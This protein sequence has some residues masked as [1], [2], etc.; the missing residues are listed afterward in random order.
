MSYLNWPKKPFDN[1]PEIPV[2]HLG[3]YTSTFCEDFSMDHL[4]FGAVYKM[5]GNCLPLDR[6]KDSRSYLCDYEIN[7]AFPDFFPT[8]H[9]PNEELGIPTDWKFDWFKELSIYHSW[10]TFGSFF[11]VPNRIKIFHNE[12][13][14]S[15]IGLA[16]SNYLVHGKLLTLADFRLCQRLNTEK[17]DQLERLTVFLSFQPI[18]ITKE[19]LYYFL[20][21]PSPESVKIA[22]TNFSQLI[23]DLE[24]MGTSIEDLITSLYALL[25]CE[26]IEK[27][28]FANEIKSTQAT[29]LQRIE[30]LGKVWNGRYQDFLSSV[31]PDKLFLPFGNRSSDTAIK[32]L[33]HLKQAVQ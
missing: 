1:L 11:C 7:Q 26:T 4:R 21:L 30:T 28:G 6:S 23:S 25:N 20:P 33:K 10:A 32:F 5:V 13:V 18:L 27:I 2:Y 31:S 9:T 8:V 14:P 12:V 17:L 19:Y 15:A 22:V 3:F 16:L 24:M 29:M